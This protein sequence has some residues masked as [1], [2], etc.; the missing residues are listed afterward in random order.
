[1]S[2]T[3][4]SD[5]V[6][7]ITSVQRRRRWSASEKVRMVEETFEPRSTVSLVARR[8]GVAPNQLFT[9]RRL[10]AQGALTAAGAEDEAGTVPRGAD[11][12]FRG[13]AQ[14][15]LVLVKAFSIALRSVSR[16]GGSAGSP[17]PS[18]ISRTLGPLWLNGLSKMT[19][20]PGRSSGTSTRAR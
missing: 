11:S 18:I 19:T 13:L 2:M 6:E 14:E 16:A 20:S 9:W 5:R 15:R 17:A 12:S 4:T 1:M 8:H 7:I 10:A 3:S